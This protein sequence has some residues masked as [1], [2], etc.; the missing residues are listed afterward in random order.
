MKTTTQMAKVSFAVMSKSSKCIASLM[1]NSWVAITVNLITQTLASVSQ[2]T[3][4]KAC[5]SPKMSVPNAII[6]NITKG[7]LKM[8]ANVYTIEN[9]LI[10]KTYRSSTLTGEIISAEVHPKAVWYKDCESYL[11]EIRNEN[12]GYSFRTVAVKVGD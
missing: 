11:V 9:L 4:P 10:G 6:A 12:G 2:F 1:V 7:K 5:L 8:S 3:P